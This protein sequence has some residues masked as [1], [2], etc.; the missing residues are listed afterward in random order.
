MFITGFEAFHLDINQL[1][2]KATL[3]VSLSAFTKLL[4][5]LFDFDIMLLQLMFFCQVC[6]KGISAI[7]DLRTSLAFYFYVIFS[8]LLIRMLKVLMTL[9]ID[10]VDKGCTTMLKYIVIRAPAHIS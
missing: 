10:H 6:F 4:K 8:H 3:K 9:S 7:T 1:S 5:L 2:A